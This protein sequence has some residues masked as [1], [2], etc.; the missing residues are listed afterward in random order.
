MA[1]NENSKI[2]ALEKVRR[3]AHTIQLA[4]SEGVSRSLAELL[5]QNLTE[6]LSG[7]HRLGISDDALAEACEVGTARANPTDCAA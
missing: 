4:T 6:A 1:T 2:L 7:A 5:L 3:A